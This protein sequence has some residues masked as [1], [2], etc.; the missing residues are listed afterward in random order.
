[1]LPAEDSNEAQVR[2]LLSC[3]LLSGTVDEVIEKLS[4]LKHIDYEDI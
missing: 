4:E 2:L 3:Q 1:L